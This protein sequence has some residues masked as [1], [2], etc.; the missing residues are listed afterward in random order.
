MWRSTGAKF[1]LSFL[2]PPSNGA[3]R[4]KVVY[5]ADIISV[6]YLPYVKKEIKTLKL[7]E[8]DIEYSKKYLDRSEITRLLMSTGDTDDMIVVKNGLLTD[9]SIA[10][11]ALLRDGVWITPKTPLLKG[12]MR[13][14]LLRDGLLEEADI[15]AADIAGFEAVAIMNALRGFEPLGGVN[16]VVRF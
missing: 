12:T 14:K 16:G 2:S 13:E 5:D 4:C 6:E 3:Y 11:I 10:N 8:A 15:L 9:A 7:V 1:D